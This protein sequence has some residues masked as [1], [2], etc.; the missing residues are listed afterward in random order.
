MSSLILCEKYSRWAAAFRRELRKP[1]HE[2]AIKIMEVRSLAQ[3]E[4]ELHASPHSMAA[5][6]VI[7][8][9]LAAVCRSLRACSDLFPH[10][11][12]V[13]LAAR[14][15]EPQELTL[16]EAGAIQVIFSPRSLASLRRMASR[17]LARAPQEGLKLEEAI[18]NRLP[19]Q[20]SHARRP[21]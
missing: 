17:H 9:N 7:P 10:V 2:A 1:P 15:M 8:Q 12:F 14:G 18:R 5:V 21:F 6:E 16:R 11:R 4:R 20:E 13:A 19:W 3:C